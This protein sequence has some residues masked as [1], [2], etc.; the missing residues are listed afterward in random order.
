MTREEIRK[1]VEELLKLHRDL[2]DI[3]PRL[4]WRQGHLDISSNRYIMADDIVL[5]SLSYTDV[6]AG[7]TASN[8][9]LLV[10][11]I[12]NWLETKEGKKN[13]T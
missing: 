12:S 11:K 3:S 2:P 8:W 5:Y 9:I 7:L 4:I 13:A 1:Q 10:N 6:Q